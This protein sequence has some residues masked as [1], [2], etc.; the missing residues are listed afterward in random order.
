MELTDSLK[1]LLIEA[2]KQLKGSARRRFMALT[3]KELGTGGQNIAVHR[4]RM[5]SR[6]HP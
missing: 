1:K 5:E 2:Q 6:Y 3:V 4:T